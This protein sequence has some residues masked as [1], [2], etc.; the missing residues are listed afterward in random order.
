VTRIDISRL[1][2]RHQAFVKNNEKHGEIYKKPCKEKPKAL[3]EAFDSLL[4]LDYAWE[5][6]RQRL[7]GEIDE[8]R[9][10]PLKFRIAKNCT[11]EPDFLSRK[12]Q[13]FIIDEVKGS[14]KQKGGRDSRTR[15][16]V[17]AFMYQWFSWRGVLREKGVW[18][19]ELIHS[20]NAEVEPMD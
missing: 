16:E 8:W 20:T 15:L 12:G 18:C 17:A 4:E 5:L 6:E 1:S 3:G 19:L 14:W 13:Q 7:A 11:Y 9:Y 10:H 2:Q